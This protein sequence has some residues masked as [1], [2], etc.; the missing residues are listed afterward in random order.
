MQL[1]QKR[2]FLLPLAATLVILLAGCSRNAA[3]GY[4]GYVEGSLCM[5]PHLS[6]ATG[7][8]VCNSWR[9][10]RNEPGAQNHVLRSAS[11]VEGHLHAAPDQ[12]PDLQ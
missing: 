10:G 2:S 4:Q 8:S 5:L 3:T 11:V 9:D 7:S 12:L 6:L 1:H